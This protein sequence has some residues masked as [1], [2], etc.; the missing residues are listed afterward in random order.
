MTRDPH[1]LRAA[2][3]RCSLFRFARGLVTFAGDPPRRSRR[4]A[5]TTVPS[6]CARRR[7]RVDSTLG[8]FYPTPYITV[9]GD[10][11]VGGRLLAARDLR[12]SDTAALRPA[13]GVPYPQQLPSSL[14]FAATT[15]GRTP[16]R[17]I[18]FSNPNLPVLSPVRYPTVGNYYY[19]PRVIQHDA[20]GY[21]RH[22]LDRSELT[23][24]SR[25]HKCKQSS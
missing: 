12:R 18:S 21:Q 6:T 24:D 23:A 5:V 3:L 4:V 20:V 17:G 8:T 22:Q 7:E 25:K 11:P 19:G 15:A 9:G 14:T 2:C 16:D 10:V 13:L 1:A